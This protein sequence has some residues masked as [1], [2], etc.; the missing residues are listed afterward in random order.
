MKKAI[1]IGLGLLMIGRTGF[2]DIGNQVLFDQTRYNALEKAFNEETKIFNQDFVF[3]DEDKKTIEAH[4]QFITAALKEMEKSWAS[5]LLG[6]SS[7]LV[8]QLA[9]VVFSAAVANVIV[10]WQ[11]LTFHHYNSA[12]SLQNK[13]MS[14]FELLKHTYTYDIP[15]AL[16]LI[17]AEQNYDTAGR[18]YPISRAQATWKSL[19]KGGTPFKG[20]TSNDDESPFVKAGLVAPLIAPLIIIPLFYL[21]DYLWRK[22]SVC[23]EKIWE[24]KKDIQ[25]DQAMIDALSVSQ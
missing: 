18:G 19:K 2:A 1:L 14:Y 17:S 9:C 21:D 16:G 3:Q 20:V 6:T 15:S 5:R 7:I 10:T 8:G 25:R 24:L 11:I 22:D 13:P 4:K 12:S 23:K